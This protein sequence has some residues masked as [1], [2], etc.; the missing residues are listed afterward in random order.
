M[1]IE[2][3][4]EEVRGW[5]HDHCPD[6][7]RG[8][9]SPVTIGSKRPISDELL[10][11]RHAF[12]GRGWSVPSW[13]KEYGGG[14]LSPEEITVLNEELQAIKARVPMG[15]MGTSMIGPTLLEYGSEEQK[16][17]HIPKIALG[18]VSWC[19][20][21]SEPGAGSDLAG[22]QTRMVDKG[23]YYEVNGQKIW[24][25]GANFADWIFTLVRTDPE[26]PKH[27][28]I[29][30]ILIDMDQ[31]GITVK[32]IQLISGTSPFCETFF[33]NAIAQKDELVGE[34]NRG[35][36]VGKRLLQHERS[37]L[38]G[39]RG[40]APQRRRGRPRNGM[41]DL[42][43]RYLGEDKSGRIAE[44]AAR[45]KVVRFAMDQASFTATTRRARE[46]SSSAQTPGETTSIFKYYG[47]Q[48]ARESAEFQTYLMGTQGHGWEGPGFE[49]H[50]IGA[51]RGFL[52]SRAVTIYGGTNEIQMN[53]IAKRVLGLPD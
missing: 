38:G 43:R 45:D 40:A 27:D 16:K 20:G 44:P 10:A 32:P 53:I 9:G 31:P 3:F 5:L 12:G 17:R 26:A 1:T 41:A 28:G 25:S 36:T 47:A 42:A 51:N 15:G 14:G 33:D 4:R 34:L 46:E 18:D 21:Y 50:E 37:G 29:S 7:A 52:S 19:Q 11:W 24:T 6:A 2:A 8:P 48:M 39:L 35:W 23:D 30:F 22:L 13:P 49:P